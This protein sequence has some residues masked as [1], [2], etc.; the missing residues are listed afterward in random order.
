MDDSRAGPRQQR[1]NDQAHALARAGRRKTENVL[2][3]VVAKVMLTQTT[4]DDTVLT[5]Q[6]GGLRLAFARPPR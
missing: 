3:A 1:R 2:R 4:K 6:T 5:E